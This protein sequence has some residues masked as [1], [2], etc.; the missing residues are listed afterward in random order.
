VTACKACNHRRKRAA[1][2]TR[3]GCDSPVRPTG[4]GRP[5]QAFSRTTWQHTPRGEPSSPAQTQRTLTAQQ[6]PAAE[7]PLAVRSSQSTDTGP[8][9]R[10]R[11]HATRPIL[12]GSAG[13]TTSHAG[14]D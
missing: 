1:P 11:A 7:R 3:P 5:S 4:P 9:T 14:L 12:P 13:R 8:A 10:T 6:R 2:Q